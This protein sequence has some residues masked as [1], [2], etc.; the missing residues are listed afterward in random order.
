M[1]S[2]EDSRTVC[3]YGAECYQ[4]NPV[5][6]KKYKHPK[7][8]L[9]SR[10]PGESP[11]KR[12]KNGSEVPEV[13]RLTEPDPL[14]VSKLTDIVDDESYTDREEVRDE[15]EL[16]ILSKLPDDMATKIR[17]LFLMDLP[18]DFYEF[19]KFCEKLPIKPV[20]KALN[21]V[22]LE[23]VGPFDVLGGNTKDC[24][25]EEALR[26]Y[27]YYYDPPEFLTVLKADEKTELHYGYYRDDP[28]EMPA[29]VGSNATTEGCKITTISAN[30]FGALNYHIE[31]IH[32]TADPFRKMQITRIQSELAKYT[33]SLDI[34]LSYLT[35]EM[36]ARRSKCVSKGWHGGG[37]VV[38]YDKK[39]DVG[40]RDIIENRST[41]E[42][43]F[44][45]FEKVESETEEA[46]LWGKLQ[47]YLTNTNIANDECDFGGSLE[48]GMA[49]FCSGL[50]KLHTPILQV[51]PT[52]YELLNRPQ[53]AEIIRAHIPNRV[54]GG[55][56]NTI[57]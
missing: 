1:S 7:K 5:H 9:P 51:L 47:P 38:P 24:T 6:L 37:I 35:S 32:K 2:D 41:L 25:K 20:R 28:S 49:M 29:Y 52:A 15:R 31:K 57:S 33:K 55:N 8:R 17:T 11:E 16:I 26:H 34:S 10:D 30:L 12:P 46:A 21:A 36:R 53:F 4:K 45:S 44:T 3:K 54:K 18:E 43:L 40:Y 19:Y 39:T 48:F 23:L 14:P 42:K 50:T 13:G 27:R 56:V 22:G